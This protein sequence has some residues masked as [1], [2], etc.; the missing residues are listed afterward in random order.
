MLSLACSNGDVRLYG[1]AVTS[2]GTVEV[3]YESVWG[4]IMATG[5]VDRDAVVVCK[6]LGHPSGGLLSSYY[7]C[8]YGCL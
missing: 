4:L 3:C 5:W 2:E 6:E 7:T 1:G 8:M